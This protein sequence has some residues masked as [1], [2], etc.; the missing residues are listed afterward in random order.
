MRANGSRT[1]SVESVSSFGK[2][3]ISKE[4]TK[5]GKRMALDG[6]SG[7]TIDMSCNYL[8]L[9]IDEEMGVFHYA[10][11]FNPRIDSTFEK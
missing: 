7:K 11:N 10:V 6:T 8:K 9:V 5:M 2:M 3:K 4:L 1:L